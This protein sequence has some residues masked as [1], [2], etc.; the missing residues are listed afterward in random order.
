[1]LAKVAD[2]SMS[3]TKPSTHVECSDEYFEKEIKIFD[4]DAFL[5]SWLTVSISI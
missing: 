4:N 5:K 2:N 3:G 1:M